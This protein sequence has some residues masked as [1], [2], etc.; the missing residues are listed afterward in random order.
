MTERA[1]VLGFY[2][3]DRGEHMCFSNLYDQKS[4][5]FDFEVPGAFLARL[6]APVP[7]VV[8]CAFSEKAIM[9][10]K[11][12][13]MGDA[14]AYN[15]IAAAADPRKAKALGRRVQG[16]EEGL[17]DTVVCSVAFEVCYQKFSKTPS[18]QKVLLATGDRLIAE[19]T[20]N[21]ANWGIGINTGDPRVQRPAA[22]EGT[23][24][25]GW[26]LMEARAEL[27]RSQRPGRGK[28]WRWRQV[29]ATI[30]HQARSA[31]AASE[32]RLGREPST[33]RGWGANSME[34]MP[35]ILG[36]P[37]FGSSWNL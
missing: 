15:Q 23:N 29:L 13:V 12:A 30:A 1:N 31:G 21:D 37:L 26:A 36:H 11:A 28:A 16:W 9:L 22:W 8:S 2:G 3:H 18:I 27:R 25:L 5:P 19:A 20:V 17:W 6:G 33:L 24:I 32:H 14:G 35:E 4:E 7:K 34:N 10:C